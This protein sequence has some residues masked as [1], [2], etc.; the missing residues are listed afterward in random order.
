MKYWRVIAIALVTVSLIYYYFA[1]Y[2]GGKKA[3]EQ[4]GQ[5]QTSSKQWETKTDEQSSVLIKVI[6][7]QLG[8]GQNPWKFEVTFTTH[9]GD[10]DIDP[11][12]VISLSDD[13]GNN[14]QP[15]S[16]EGPGPG[17]H[18]IS[19]NLTFDAIAPTPKFVELK[20]KDVGG[21]PERS[22]KWKLE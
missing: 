21:I 11:T 20:I 16:W 17:G 7:I 18:H 8:S 6:P 13:N 12:K 14:F 15:T 9:S 5:N 22:F 4:V 2:E 3:N 10:L 19:G 1:V